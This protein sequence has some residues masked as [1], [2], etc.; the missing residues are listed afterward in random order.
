V[1]APV[2]AAEQLVVGSAVAAAMGVE[3]SV[4]V[5]AADGGDGNEFEMPAKKRPDGESPP[6]GRSCARG[7]CWLGPYSP[8]WGCADLAASSTV[9]IPCRRPPFNFQTGSQGLRAGERAH[10]SRC[11]T[12]NYSDAPWPGRLIQRWPH[13]PF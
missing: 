9:K 10:S 13:I 4:V 8:L 5:R 11:R 2:I 12:S 3:V 1:A 7:L 6:G